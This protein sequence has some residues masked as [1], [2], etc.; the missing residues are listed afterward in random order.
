G[1]I[2][3]CRKASGQSEMPLKFRKQLSEARNCG[4]AVQSRLVAGWMIE[5]ITK[6]SRQLW[7]FGAGHVGRAIVSVLAPMPEYAISWIDAARDRFPRE[8]A[9]NIDVLVAAN[10]ADMVSYAPQDAQ[11]LVLSY[12]HALDLEICHR[13]LGRGFESVGLIG[14]KTKWARFRSRLR[15]LGHSESQIAR[16]SCPIGQPGLGK[17]PQAIAV[18]V[19][20]ALLSPA[21]IAENTKQRAG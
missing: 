20:A 5:A 2:V 8:V 14:S 18:G 6:P 13:L 9:D 19:A 10:P 21:G 17:H 12:S 11:H 1:D 16:I 3:V 4:G 7:I 15:G